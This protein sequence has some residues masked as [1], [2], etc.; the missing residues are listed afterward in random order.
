MDRFESMS[1]FVAVVEAGGFSAASRKL[2]MPLATVSRKVSELEDQ[3][4]VQLLARST[5][6]IALTEAGQQYFATCRRL[7]ED[8]GEAERLAAGE[9]S[10]P[11]GGLVVSAPIVF[12]RLYLAPIVVEFLKAYPDV[13]VELRLADSI[14]NLIEEHADVAIR[15]GQL[16]DSG[17]IAVKAGE[18][19]HVVCAS[20]AYLAERGTPSHPRELAGHDCITF[21]ALQSP[22][23]WTFVNGKRVEKIPVHSRLSVSTAEAAADAAIAGVGI[24]RLLCYQVSKAITDGSLTVLMRDHEP[25]PLPIHLVHTSGRVMPQKLRVFLDFVLPRLK[26]KLVFNA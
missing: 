24:T 14:V 13:D 10:A 20:P 26:V 16:P 8:L 5:R 3:L 12:G 19:R 25:T 2:G 23:E 22:I 7:L 17:L 15:I 1:A 6:K 18:I 11:R 4:R 9:Y 21:T